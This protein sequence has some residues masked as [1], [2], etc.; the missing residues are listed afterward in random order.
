MKAGKFSDTGHRYRFNSFHR[1]DNWYSNTEILNPFFDYV[2]YNS[3]TYDVPLDKVEIAEIYFRLMTDQ[4][5]HKRKV[6][7]I[8]DFFGALGGVSRVLLQICGIFYG[9]YATFESAYQT[10]AQLYKVKSDKPI[11]KN[12]SRFPNKSNVQRM[13]LSALTRL[14]LFSHLSCIAPFIKCC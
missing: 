2:F 12:C 1:T 11:F 5:T 4:I 9:G 8:M 10:N 6:F 3:D 14:S 13:N 7:A